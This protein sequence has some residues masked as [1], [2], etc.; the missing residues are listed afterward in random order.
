MGKTHT[1]ALDTYRKLVRLRE[2]T[3]YAGER[4]NAQRAIDALLAEHPDLVARA[5]AETE[6]E[7][8]EH[9]RAAEERRSE[10]EADERERRRERDRERE[11]E[12]EGS[13]AELLARMREE[14]RLVTEAGW[15]DGCGPVPLRPPGRGIPP[16]TVGYTSPTTAGWR[17]PTKPRR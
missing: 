8:R 7:E 6:R 3:E 9:T 16:V 1:E 13:A 14:R 11:R 15:G 12:R 4:D 10:A 2:G 5:D 17:S